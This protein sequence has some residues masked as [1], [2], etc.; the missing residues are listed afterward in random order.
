MHGSKAGR[1]REWLLY[2]AR[3]VTASAPSTHQAKRVH[4]GDVIAELKGF[5][6]GVGFVLFVDNGWMQMLEGYTFE[7]PWPENAELLGLS[8]SSSSRD[9]SA[10]D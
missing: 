9:F 7:E 1:D 6:Y 4:F 10:L 3:S 2:G 8:Y 5:E